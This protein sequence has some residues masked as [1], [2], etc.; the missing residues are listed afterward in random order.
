MI[1]VKYYKTVQ[2]RDRLVTERE[3]DTMEQAL[4][5]VEE[6]EGRTLDNYAVFA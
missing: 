3:F 5:N 4:E 6:W 1:K 2:G